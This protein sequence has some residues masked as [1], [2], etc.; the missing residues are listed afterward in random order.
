[1]E[2]NNVLALIAE[3]LFPHKKKLYAD[4]NVYDEMKKH[5]VLALP[6]PIL[7]SIEITDDLRQKWEVDILKQVSHYVRYNY[8][9]SS[10]PITVPYAV[11]KGTAAAQYYPHPEYRAMGDIDIIPRI[12]DFDQA[13]KDLIENGYGVIQDL[14]REII[15]KK[16]ETIIELHRCFASLNNPIHA[17]R[18]DNLI[19]EN[20]TPSH[21]LPNEINGLVILE[22][23]SQHLEH[24]LG[25]R[26]IVD[27]M[28]Y[29]DKCLPDKHWPQFRKLVDSIGLLELA[30]VATRMCEKYLGLPRRSW[31][32]KADISLCRQLMEYVLSCGNFGAKRTSDSDVSENVFA[33][34]SNPKA[35]FR[36]LQKQG[37]ANWEL[38]RKY[39]LIKPIA[40]LYQALR[41]T[42]R[43][44]KRDHAFSK[45]RSEYLAAMKR[46]EM[47]NA[48][49]V[50][51][52]GK[53][54]YIF[55]NGEYV[56][57]T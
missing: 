30:I 42:S 43:G 39:K 2:D 41:Y 21:I 52:S 36:L 57:K 24:G 44:L 55:E 3:S 15:L 25:L 4:Q 37:L 7:P 56:K 54:I 13:L 11:L 5:A 19:F 17:Q 12:R 45:A 38:A 26:Q 20:I 49:G 22:H 14:D 35:T 8:M 34:A 47:F 9:Q 51:M 46:N 33:Y 16:N 18:L 48:L 6:A 50:K 29:V 31:C 28:M 32:E 1:M 23:I 27:W 40:W 10:L 53:G